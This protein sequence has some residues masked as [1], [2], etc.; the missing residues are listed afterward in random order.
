MSLTDTEEIYVAKIDIFSQNRDPSSV[1]M[2]NANYNIKLPSFIGNKRYIKI[3]VE[4]FNMA[5]KTLVPQEIICVRLTTC[6][7]VNSFDT[8]TGG[9][10]DIII[11]AIPTALSSNDY[12]IS[13][14][15][16]YYG[17]NIGS[18]PVGNINIRITNAHNVDLVLGDNVNDYSLQLRVEAYN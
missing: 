18:L 5:I 15:N 13:A 2:G 17:I 11:T 8:S 1:S 6:G 7:Q 12:G 3:F 9:P 4:N 16:N 10:S 14:S